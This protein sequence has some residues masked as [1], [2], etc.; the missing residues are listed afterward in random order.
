MPNVLTGRLRPAPRPTVQLIVRI[1]PVLK[2]RLSRL[3]AQRR[4]FETRLVEEALCTYLDKSVSRS[5][6]RQR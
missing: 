2:E 5:G 3:A 4:C 1:D 6:E